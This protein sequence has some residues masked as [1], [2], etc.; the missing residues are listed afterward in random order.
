VAIGLA[1]AGALVPLNDNELNIIEKI[2][3]KSEPL[4]P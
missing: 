3:Q 1:Q 4:F 2:A